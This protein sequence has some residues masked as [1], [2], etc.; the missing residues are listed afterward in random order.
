MSET[1]PRVRV[2]ISMR[3]GEMVSFQMPVG[4]M[5]WVE[6]FTGGP[7]IHPR[8]AEGVRD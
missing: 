3:T 1:K 5:A 7:A 4:R 6:L 2:R 8:F